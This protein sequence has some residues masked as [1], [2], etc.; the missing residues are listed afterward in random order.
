MGLDLRYNLNEMKIFCIGRNYVDHAKEL[1]NEIP[2][3]PI[4]FLKPQ[5]AY[6]PNNSDIP[7]PSFTKNFHY[8]TE[9]VLKMDKKGKSISE[10]KAKNFYSELTV[11]L[12]LTARDL[13]N[14]LR[15]KQLPWELSKGFDSSA[16]VG[17]FI[18]RPTDPYAMNFKLLRSGQQVQEGH[19]KNL[20][21][22]FERLISFIS[23]YFTIEQ[24][25]L[26]STGTPVGV[27]SLEKGDTVEAFVEDQKLLSSKVV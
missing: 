21:F 14:E 4:I 22:S 5:T 12:D 18:P 1:G 15:E 2:E 20:I 6:L 26:I 11:G 27:G 25:D 19:T 10:E 7:Y 8:E 17:D 16:L 23:I 13:Q 24:D 3:E 9:I